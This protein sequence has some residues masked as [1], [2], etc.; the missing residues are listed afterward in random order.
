MNIWEL[1][2]ENE[3]NNGFENEDLIVWMRTA[4]LPDFRK[5]YRRI[6]HSK[7]YKNGLPKGHYKLVIDYSKF[8]VIKK[9]NR[10]TNIIIL[11]L[12]RLS[13]SRLWWNK[14]LNTVQHFIYRG[15]KLISWIRLYCCWMLLLFIRVI[16][17]NSSYQI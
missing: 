15:Q 10:F 6:D 4:A 14:K 7:E 2:K 16:V 17:F 11:Q 1:D 12:F 9:K 8:H 13:S 5:L 3:L